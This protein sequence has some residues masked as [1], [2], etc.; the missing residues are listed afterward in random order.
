MKLVGNE[1]SESEYMPRTEAAK[2]LGVHPDTISAL[3]DNEEFEA[4]K[5]GTGESR[6][7]LLVHRESFAKFIERS[8]VVSK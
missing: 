3:A 5:I 2:R 4:V 6:Q 7:K 8:R 1:P